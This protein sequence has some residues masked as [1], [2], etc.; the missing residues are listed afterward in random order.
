M[1]VTVSAKEL[2][3]LVTCILYVIPLSDIYHSLVGAN[4]PLGS[5]NVLVV[6]TGNHVCPTMY[7]CVNIVILHI[8][9][10]NL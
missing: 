9:D 10:R 4:I 6:V 2:L 8:E 3:C 5:L 1:E 7:M